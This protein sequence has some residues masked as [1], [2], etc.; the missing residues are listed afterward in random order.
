[1]MAPMW[2]SAVISIRTY[3]C[4]LRRRQ[5]VER[6]KC[7]T[8]E[9]REM[10]GEEEGEREQIYKQCGP[11]PHLAGQQPDPTPPLAMM[12][13]CCCPRDRSVYCSDAAARICLQIRFSS[14]FPSHFLL[15][16]E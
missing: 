16:L 13:L 9:E 6:K 7:D 1:M 4:V 8:K 3:V 15:P 14:F 2:V 5:G 12:P 11:K 10:G